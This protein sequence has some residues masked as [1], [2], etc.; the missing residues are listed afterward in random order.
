MSGRLS[1]ATSHA[2][3]DF[4]ALLRCA[5]VFGDGGVRLTAH[6][7]LL[8]VTVPVTASAGLL[9]VGPTIL[10]IRVQRLAEVGR[11]DAVVPIDAIL[12]SKD[13]DEF[14]VPDAGTMPAWAAQTPP[15]AGWAP[16]GD[17][18][19][20][21]VRETAENAAVEFA[22]SLPT[23]AGEAVVRRTRRAVWGRRVSA[24]TMSVGSCVAM[25]SLGFLGDTVQR[26]G[27]AR[28]TFVRV[29]TA[30]GWSRASTAL[31]DV[32]ERS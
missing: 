2:R 7:A 12:R 5:A 32:F 30:K 15:R 27:L 22:A 23:S 21:L 24:G 8:V 28:P 25:Q 4:L 9:D 29:T 31:G 19:A 6:D 10:G 14:E 3:D 20:S 26:A 13:A 1:F 16:A 18:S 11:F 17:V